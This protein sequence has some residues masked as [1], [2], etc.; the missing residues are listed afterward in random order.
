MPRAKQPGNA[1]QPDQTPRRKKAKIGKGDDARNPL[2]VP[3][4]PPGKA[5][6]LDVRTL[7]LL[8]TGDWSDLAD[9]EWPPL[10]IR[11]WLTKADVRQVRGLL[12]LTLGRWH[13]L[14]RDSP[15]KG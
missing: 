7:L 13:E 5:L 3:N 15:A 2:A 6:E 12:L 9:L 4:I 14:R 10:S 8:S 11:R 1:D